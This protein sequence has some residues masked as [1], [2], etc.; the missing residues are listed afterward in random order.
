MRGR[1]GCVP[2]AKPHL[3]ISCSAASITASSGLLLVYCMV[4]SVSNTTSSLRG[5]CSNGPFEVSTLGVS[6]IISVFSLS[7][8]N[9]FSF[10]TAGVCPS[11]YDW[12]NYTWLVPDALNYLSLYWEMVDFWCWPD[13]IDRCDKSLYSL[14]FLSLIDFFESTWFKCWDDYFY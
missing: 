6:L 11:T 12:V 14:Y 5:T 10:C 3:F 7:I 4:F 8:Y 9:A 13:Y 1:L 2:K